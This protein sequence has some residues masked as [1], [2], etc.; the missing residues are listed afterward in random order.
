MAKMLKQRSRKVGTASRQKRR[1]LIRLELDKICREIVLLRDKN[2][3]QHCGKYVEG[4]NAHRSHIIPRSRGNAL[5][6][7]IDNQILF[8][9]YCHIQWWHKN[10]LEAQEWFK[11]KYPERYEY[12]MEHKND[13]A[14]RPLEDLEELLTELQR[15]KRGIADG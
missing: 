13:I 1:K 11:N 7:C 9:F 6:W 8:C 14:K 3:C 15:E 12:L 2:C 4:S 10:I 5:R